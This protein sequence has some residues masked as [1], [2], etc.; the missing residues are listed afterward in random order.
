MKKDPSKNERIYLIA[1]TL[2]VIIFIASYFIP[3]TMMDKSIWNW[4]SVTP[5]FLCLPLL[6][7][8]P[9]GAYT[10]SNFKATPLVDQPETE[11]D[12]Y[13]DAQNAQHY[14]DVF[15]GLWLPSFIYGSVFS[16]SFLFVAFLKDKICF[17]NTSL[18]YTFILMILGSMSGF[19]ISFRI[20]LSLFSN[21]QN[22]KQE[23]PFSGHHYAQ[24]TKNLDKREFGYGYTGGSNTRSVTRHS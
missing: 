12:D 6:F 13:S 2:I 23:T 18:A 7:S 20:Y 19:Y 22:K 5:L 14:G 11:L 24:R 3:S 4:I 9:V 17:E 10:A 15:K 16:V 8:I 1:A 21:E